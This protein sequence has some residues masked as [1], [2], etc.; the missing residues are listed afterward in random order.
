MFASHT[1]VQR[2]VSHTISMPTIFTIN[3]IQFLFAIR[4]PPHKSNLLTFHTILSV[5]YHMN[6]RIIISLSIV[7]AIQLNKQ[8]HKLCDMV[9]I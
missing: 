4:S 3:N 9:M 8:S 1:I 7:V 6:K 5:Y 2:R